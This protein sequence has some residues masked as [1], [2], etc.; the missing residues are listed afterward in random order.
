ME[1]RKSLGFVEECH[2]LTTVA[3]V[4]DLQCCERR[5]VELK[6]RT[7]PHMAFLTL[8][9]GLPVP[10]GQAPGQQELCSQE[11]GSSGDTGLH[12]SDLL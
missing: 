9:T 7:S 8:P 3:Q 6:A 10:D 12:V 2:T 1:A 5:G 4:K 11:P